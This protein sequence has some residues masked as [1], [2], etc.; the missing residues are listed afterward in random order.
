MS[1]EPSEEH[2]KPLF[3]DITADEDEPEITEMESLC[4]NCE[5][6]G[7]TRLFLT[8][9]PFFREVVVSSF[10]CDECGYRNAELMPASR[11]QD[12]ASV[13]KVK[14][15]KPQDLNRQVVQSHHAV[16][17]IPHLDFEAA[18]KKGVLTTVEGILTRAIDNLGEG[19]VLRK[20]QE[21]EMAAKIDEFVDKLKALLELET[22]F[23][24]EL[25]DP[26]GNS[27]VENIYPL[28][29]VSCLPDP[30]IIVSYY[31]RTRK[32]DIEIGILAEDAEEEGGGEAD[33]KVGTKDQEF[34]TT[35]EVMH[36]PT[37]CPNCN[38]PCETN[39]KLVNIPFFKEVVIM[40]TNCEAC[41][42][43]DNEVKSGGGMEDKG[44]SITVRIETSED[45]SRDVLKSETACIRIPE[46]DFETE[47]GTLGG[48]FTTVE[49]LLEDIKG[50]LRDSNPFL[51]G[52]SSLPSTSSKLQAFC[53]KVDE[54]I[55]GTRTKVHIVVDDPA[56]NSYIQSLTAPDPD[57]QLTV[58]DYERNFEQN[59]D[60][61][62]NDIKTE[63]YAT[64]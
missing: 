29:V 41:G 15:Q 40:A 50:Q 24:I 38:A 58:E 63:N 51:V 48:K 53:E 11:I 43:R 18:P 42:H 7:M 37:N 60:L 5:E 56:G 10:T 23:D 52:D 31:S 61:G 54:I 46:L 28:H 49:G 35:N 16:V 14:I 57:P 30:Q 44:R 9:I 1:G 34:D 26:T 13:Y 3:R 39:M 25:E 55:K 19:Q 8:K 32:Q 64:S 4:V 62:L 59:E 12:Y 45:M 27:F 22:T 2:K 20:I 17:R 33:G 21:P 6:Q 47:M 36:F